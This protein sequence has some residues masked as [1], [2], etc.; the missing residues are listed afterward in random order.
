[1]MS[2]KKLEK[3]EKILG[4]ETVQ[5]FEAS[6]KEDLETSII[7]AES[8]MKQAQEELESNPKYQQIKEDLKALSAGLKEV[9]KRQNAV[10]QFALHLLEEKGQQ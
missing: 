9:K 7:T 4:K 8:A 5:S 10:I 3:I 2:D 6:S 1:M